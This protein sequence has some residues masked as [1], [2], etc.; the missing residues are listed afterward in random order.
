MI[1]T[2][3]LQL[4]LEIEQAAIDNDLAGSGTTFG[5]FLGNILSGVMVI[6]LLMALLYLVW[7]AVQWI[8]S[9]GDSSKVQKA[10]DRMTQAMVG[11][12][13]LSATLAIFGLLQ[14]FLGVEIIQFDF[15]GSSSSSTPDAGLWEGFD[16]L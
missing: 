3:L 4:T 10:R 8:Y 14:A 11:I 9:G 5:G 7:G 2:S 12:L 1:P 16:R 13:V 6:A 15:G